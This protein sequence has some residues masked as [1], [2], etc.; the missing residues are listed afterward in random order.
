ML[1]PHLSLKLRP[2]SLTLSALLLLTSGTLIFARWKSSESRLVQTSPQSQSPGN[3]VAELE[4]EL[5][6]ATPTGFEPAEITRPQGRFLLAVD[7]RSGLNDLD[8]Y[9]ERETEGRV[10]VALGRRGKLKW[11]E[12]LDLPPGHYFLRATNDATWR[13]SLTLT[14][15]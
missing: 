10:N 5:V 15:R 9:L 14:S 8:L 3:S 11:R 1:F 2:L 13:C 12:V 4:A 6:T 7:N